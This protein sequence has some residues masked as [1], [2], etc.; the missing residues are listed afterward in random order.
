[1]TRCSSAARSFQI[2]GRIAVGPLERIGEH[3]LGAERADDAFAL[4]R[5]LVRHAELE[6]VA[7]HR[8]D[9]REGDPGVPTRRVEDGPTAAQASVPFGG[10]D[11]PEARTVLDAAPRVDALD[12]RPEL[13]TQARPDAMQRHERRVADALQDRATDA[14][15]HEL[16][17]ESR[18]AKRLVEA[19]P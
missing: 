11:H 12:L 2:A 18:H 19:A 16:R 15:A 10:E 17:R 1:M 14:L 7:A 9:H 4:D 5:D 3:E 13:A 6:D 8:A